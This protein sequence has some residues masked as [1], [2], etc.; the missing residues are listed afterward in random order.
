MCHAA[1]TTKELSNV[2]LS[3][4]K[5]E[6]EQICT[7]LYVDWSLNPNVHFQFF[8]LFSRKKLILKFHGIFVKW[9][10]TSYNML[11]IR[12][13]LKRGIKKLECGIG[14]AFI[15]DI[16]ELSIRRNYWQKRGFISP[17]FQRWPNFLKME[18]FLASPKSW[19]RFTF[20]IVWK[21]KPLRQEKIQ[22]G[23]NS[24]LLML[25]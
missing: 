11:K 25:F 20:W 3:C 12:Y 8:I 15:W 18:W 17:K 5:G 10:L 6:K 19:A 22:R 24:S 4:Q 9:Q 2:S 14:I 7:V 21:Y 23:S 1:V 16:S 13:P